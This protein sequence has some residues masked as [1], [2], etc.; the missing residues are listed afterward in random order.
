MSTQQTEL[1]Q[2]SWI[3]KPKPDEG[4]LSQQAIDKIEAWDK[5][6]E[7]KEKQN[8]NFFRMEDGEEVEVYFDM[9]D[10]NTGIR[11]GK[12]WKTN[13]KTNER[14]QIEREKMHFVLWNEKLQRTQ[15]WSPSDTWAR[16][17]IQGIKDFGPGLK[18]RRKGEG[19]DT[20][21]TFLPPGFKRAM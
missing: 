8:S 13:K 5:E 17:A 4:P 9:E 15:I 12:A 18:I 14:E 20:D 21:Y 2:E 19:L 1:K 16:K 11:L 3:N 6:L 7:L 10:P